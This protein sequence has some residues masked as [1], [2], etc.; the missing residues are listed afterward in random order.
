MR[1]RLSER[2]PRLLAS[3]A[4]LLATIA[5]GSYSET[6]IASQGAATSH[7]TQAPLQE[8]QDTG[9]LNRLRLLSE[10]QYL[11][12]VRYVFGPDVAPEPHFPPAQ[13]RDGLLAL[14]S[15]ITGVTTAQLELYQKAAVT[16]ANTVVDP[17]YRAF[18]ITCKPRNENKA[19]KACASQFLKEKGRLLNRRPLTRNELD[20]F[21]AEA[22]KTADQLKDFYVGIGVALEAMLVSP[23]VLFVAE[24]TE[25][26]PARPG[27]QRLDAFS[28]ATRMS[29]FL[30]NA[31]P[32][33][34]VLKAAESGEIQTPEGRARVVDMMLSS[35]RL[36]AGVRAFF[37][38]MFGF[39]DFNS[40]SKD[41]A[42]YPQFTGQV[43]QDARE[44]TLRTIVDHLVNKRG[45]YRDLFTTR[46]TFISP[47]LAVLYGEPAPAGW[48][49]YTDPPDSPR[50]GLL[51]QVSFLALHSHPTRSSPTLRGK[52]LRETLLCQRV[53]P[54]PPNVDFSAVDNPDSPF[55]TQRE[56]VAFH[57]KN[58]VCAGC[59]KITDPMGLALENFDSSGRFREEERGSKIDASGTL[60][61]KSFS[62]VVSLGKVLHDNPGLTSCLVQRIYSYGAGGA[63]R[64]EDKKTLEYFN[65]RFAEAG[66]RVPDLLRTIALSNAFS[67]IVAPKSPAPAV[68]TASATN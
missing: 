64:P 44:Q 41:P 18:L 27:R 51:S 7:Q 42:T 57:L 26:D 5:L 13:R 56:R 35:R 54:P 45:D 21:V 25:A 58:P 19:D 31:A 4:A 28:L 65:A 6:S 68:T 33:D 50:A 59:H 3:A 1:L 23:N 16:I 15:S 67:E 32:D 12:T 52:A 14:G 48:T 20:A 46:E 40:L 2:C 66:Y 36:D 24:A 61:G 49:P 8:P 53:P 9:S 29:L 43:A 34:N 30:W 55:A 62:G 47:A 22:N 37:D 63:V 39:D 38:D 11:N 60:D 10:E 17:K